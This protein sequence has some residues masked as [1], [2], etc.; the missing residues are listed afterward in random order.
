MLFLSKH[1]YLSIMGNTTLNRLYT[2]VILLL[3]A[4]FLNSCDESKPTDAHKFNKDLGKFNRTIHKVDKTM[5]L[6]DSMQMEIDKVE[7]EL[8][9]GKIT[10]E[11]A[12]KRLNVIN[13]THGRQIAK[14]SNYHP[15]YGLPQWAKDLGLTEPQGMVLDKDF[16][17]VTSEDNPVEGYNSVTLVY[18]GRYE[19]AMKQAEIIARKAH[20]PM[21]KE[22]KNARELEKKYGDV[23]LKGAIYMNFELGA[24]DNPRYNIAIT[25]DEN[26]T[27]TISATDA[28]KMDEL[29][30]SQTG[31]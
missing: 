27:L 13:T 23:I 15:A 28:Q 8:A 1:K 4:M 19:K 26:G 21:T 20:I 18:K 17:Q 10:P 7:K 25:V 14:N 9:E 29:I 16:S 5:D 24:Q 3:A 12:H 31:K 11:Y 6:M 2:V 22:Y 30:S